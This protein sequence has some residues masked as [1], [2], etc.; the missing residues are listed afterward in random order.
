MKSLGRCLLVATATLLLTVSSFAQ[1]DADQ[2]FMS[3][4]AQDGMKKIQSAY[5]ALQ[6][7]QNPQ[8]RAYAQQVLND[9]GDAQNELIYLANKEFVQLP[10]ELDTKDQ[11]SLQALSQLQ[12]PAFDKAYMSAMVDDDQTKL[13]QEAA[14]VDNLAI[15]DWASKTLP[16]LQGDLK[17]AQ[18]VAPAVGVR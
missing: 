8:V 6:N 9:Y 5:M 7:S 3:Q 2:K 13:K 1:S 4:L 17:Q 15:A 12:G 18:K 11:D 10:R 14:K 16:T